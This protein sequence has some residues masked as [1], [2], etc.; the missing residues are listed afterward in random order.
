MR[1]LNQKS[2]AIF[3]KLID[4]L[5]EPGDHKKIDHTNGAFMPAIIEHIGTGTINNLKYDSFSICHY[6]NKTLNGQRKLR[7][8]SGILNMVPILKKYHSNKE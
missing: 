8:Q 1:K 5:N 4:G 3:N 7:T 6:Y 2:T